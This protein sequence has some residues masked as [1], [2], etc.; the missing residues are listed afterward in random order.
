MEN[1]YDN[2]RKIVRDI[3]ITMVLSSII[4]RKNIYFNSTD[5]SSIEKTRTGEKARV[6][7]EHTEITD[8]TLTRPRSGFK[9]IQLVQQKFIYYEER[10]SAW[11]EG[12]REIER[13]T[14]SAVKLK[15]EKHTCWLRLLSVPYINYLLLILFT[16]KR[17]TCLCVLNSLYRVKRKTEARLKNWKRLF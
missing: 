14:F 6:P 8:T 5:N 3:T 13:T 4:S 10:V 11:N 17:K 12:V 2:R 16:F 9:T 7:S 1:V 15:F